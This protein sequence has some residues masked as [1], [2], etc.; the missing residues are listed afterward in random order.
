MHAY[1][2]VVGVL[3]V[4]IFCGQ[5][6]AIWPFDVSANADAELQSNTDKEDKRIA[7]IGMFIVNTNVDHPFLYVSYC[8]NQF[9]DFG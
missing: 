2:Q 7:V 6:K 8:V 9:T 1:W 5:S 3:V 4:G